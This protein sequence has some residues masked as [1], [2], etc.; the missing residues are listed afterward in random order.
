MQAG[1]LRQRVT[2]Q[3]AVVTRDSYGAD[4]PA[5]QDLA[6]V[7]ARVVTTSGTETIGVEQVA[8]AT[9]VHEVTIRWR[10][11]VQ[12]TMRLLW[13]G[14][15]LLIH[16]VLDDHLKRELVLSCSEIIDE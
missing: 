4:A 7:W 12:P 11:D 1:K 16:A 15:T 8:L 3:Q 13:E 9:V 10:G 14:H 2:I 6:T 5:W